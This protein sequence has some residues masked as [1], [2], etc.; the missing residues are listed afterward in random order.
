[1]PDLRAGTGAASSCSLFCSS[2]CIARATWCC[3][4]SLGV[5]SLPP[6]VEEVVDPLQQGGFGLAVWGWEAAEEEAGGQEEEG[7]GPQYIG[8]REG[9]VAQEAQGERQGFPGCLSHKAGTCLESRYGGSKLGAEVDGVEP[10]P[11]SWR[12][13][14]W[15]RA[16]NWGQRG[17]RL[18]TNLLNKLCN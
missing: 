9:I 18:P 12:D 11:S 6:A 3:F 17:W 8:R 7:P 10:L 4:P 15:R 16:G 2:G 5:E 1:M 13:G 14:A